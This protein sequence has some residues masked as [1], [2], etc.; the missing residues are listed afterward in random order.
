M[1]AKHAN[2]SSV[3]GKLK[4]DNWI[5]SKTNFSQQG[6]SARNSTHFSSPAQDPILLLVYNLRMHYFNWQHYNAFI[7]F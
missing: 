5:I 7:I 4:W 3:L 2:G 1:D 6:C